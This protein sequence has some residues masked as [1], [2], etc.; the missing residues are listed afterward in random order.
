M[1]TKALLSFIFDVTV[2]VPSLVNLMALPNRLE[3]TCI[4]LP[5]SLM[6][7]RISPVVVKYFILPALASPKKSEYRPSNLFSI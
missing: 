2:I 1:L 6:I 7:T 5:P 3:T 4:I